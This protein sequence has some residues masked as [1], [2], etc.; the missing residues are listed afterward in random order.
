MKPERSAAEGSSVRPTF[1]LIGGRAVALAGAFALPM[2]LVRVFS[3]AEFGTY[4]QFF[5][6]YSTLFGLAQLG[7]AE[8]LFYF[9]PHASRH[10]GRYV[11]NSLLA[12]AG[13]GLAGAAFL[14]AGGPRIARW[15]NNAD[16]GRL[17]PLVGLYLLLMLASCGL[18]IVMVAR[19]RYTAAALSYAGSELARVAFYIVPVLLVPRLQSLLW[20]AIVFGA[21]RL[22][23]AAWYLG[24]EFGPELRPDRGL[25]SQQWAYALPF[26]LAV[27]VEI[28]Q[29][30]LHQYAVSWYFDAATFAVYSVGC[31][32][33]PVVDLVAT[34]AANVMMVRMA[35]DA[36]TGNTSAAVGMWK[37]TVRKLA[38]VF[39]PLV[40]MLLVAAPH[41]I[42][43][44]FTEAYRASTP[45]FMIW[46]VAI[47]FAA[48]P[49]DAVLR[50]HAQTRFLLLLNGVRL[51][52][53]AVLIHPL[54]SALHLPGAV[55]LTVLALAVGKALALVRIKDLFGVPLGDLLPWRRLAVTGLAAAS[56]MLPA[57]MV[58][59]R[60]GGPTLPG[61]LGIAVT[62][63][64]SYV[65]LALGLGALEPDER[66]QVTRW[67]RAWMAAPFR[68]KEP[69]R[70]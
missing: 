3:Q 59:S 21:L 67:G 17:L 34:S 42:V 2:V 49:V 12:L 11:A 46:S 53:V 56:A 20:G 41:L 51:V 58:A 10:R 9:L 57:W 15:M 6:V 64:T 62:Y 36:R 44:L 60:G 31:L 40:A 48:L 45:L 27:L 23:A 4:K 68:A 55:L 28:V 37:D 13:G 16:L 66:S 61:L 32:Q 38:L 18:E 24:R 19:Q 39:F 54:L 29:A 70:G 47:L 1:L 69:Q 30:N 33:V 5:L 7:M 43:L 63:A 65:V 26:E 8:S 50:V 35:A 22:G 14:I 25:M 52:L